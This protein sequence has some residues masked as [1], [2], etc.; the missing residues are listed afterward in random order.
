MVSTEKYTN[1]IFAL[2]NKFSP[3]FADFQKFGAEFYTVSLPFATDLK[4]KRLVLIVG[5]D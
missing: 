1:M 3:C 2:N 5:T 4:K